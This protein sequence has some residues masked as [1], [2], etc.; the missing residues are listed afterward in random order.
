MTK[1]KKIKKEQHTNK[2]RILLTI[3]RLGQG[4]NYVSGLKRKIRKY[5]N[6]KTIDKPEPWT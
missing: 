5:T 6:D 2:R 1:Q 4:K 3:Q